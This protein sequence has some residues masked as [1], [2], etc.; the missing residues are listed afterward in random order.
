MGEVWK[1]RETRLNR[2]VAIKQ[3]NN[4]HLARFEKD[5]RAIASLNHPNI[6][7]LYDV[8]QDYLVMKYIEGHPLSGRYA[9]EDA[10]RFAIQIANA[11]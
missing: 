10:I 3:L 8:G 2:L 7:Q 4:Q 11:L 1:A 9:T 5:A 6:C